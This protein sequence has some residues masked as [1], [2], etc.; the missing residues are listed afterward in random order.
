MRL[1]AISTLTV[2]A[3]VGWVVGGGRL[4]LG[5]PHPAAAAAT[6][7]DASPVSTS[8][9][10]QSPRSS[11]GTVTI[12]RGYGGHFFTDADVA[13]RSLNFVVDTGATTVAL[14]RDDA[15][16]LGVDVENLA[17]DHQAQ[18]AAGV[19]RVAQTML[20]QLRIGDIQV[21][22]VPAVVLDEQTGIALLGQS[23]LG[24]IDKVSIEGD[25]MTLTKL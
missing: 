8:S 24:R 2:A 3:M 16:R 10:W 11:P 9:D 15:E 23:F 4:P 17:F 18:T 22:N 14:S 13:G 6:P 12:K 25:T 21:L 19:T 20:P 1:F 5:A 7:T